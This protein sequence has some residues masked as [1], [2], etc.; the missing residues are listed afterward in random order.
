MVKQPEKQNIKIVLSRNYEFKEKDEESDTIFK[1][2]FLKGLPKE[3]ARD[4]KMSDLIVRKSMPFAEE[5]NAINLF[6]SVLSSLRRDR[7]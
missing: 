3:E 2:T 5:R 4:R 1:N 6:N 7:R